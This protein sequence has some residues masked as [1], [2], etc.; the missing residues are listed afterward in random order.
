MEKANLAIIVLLVLTLFSATGFAIYTIFF[1]P[2]T[3][4]TQQSVK[5]ALT[6]TSA[7]VEQT[8]EN[9]VSLTL[10]K[11]NNWAIPN[12]SS[13]VL[14]RDT[15]NILAEKDPEKIYKFFEQ[16]CSTITI[17]NKCYAEP[18]NEEEKMTNALFMIK[19]PLLISL[20]NNNLYNSA[21]LI[22]L[23]H[24]ILT[25]ENFIHSVNV[26][27]QKEPISVKLLDSKIDDNESK[28]DSG[29]ITT[30]EIISEIRQSDY[31]SKLGENEK[32]SEPIMKQIY[33]IIHT[34]ISLNKQSILSKFEESN[35]TDIPIRLFVI[36]TI[37][38]FP[39][40][41]FFSEKMMSKPSCDIL[42][43]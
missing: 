18:K 39:L 14:F 4:N 43:S 42:Q 20:L 1:S 28:S 16:N 34:N 38:G 29:L 26:N 23:L 8:P 12:S 40:L 19:K 41:W 15:L 2:K 25:L 3:S 22:L 6:N 5:Q 9:T 27:E 24:N 36:S 21:A 11:P 13:T 35:S 31:D 33:D 30:K 37:Y 32:F 17:P 7:M 10:A